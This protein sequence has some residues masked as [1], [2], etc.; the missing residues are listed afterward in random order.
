MNKTSL[1]RISGPIIAII[2]VLLTACYQVYAKFFCNVSPW[3]NFDTV[4]FF[5]CIGFSM[6]CC[7]PIWIEINRSN[8]GNE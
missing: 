8:V 2:I 6:L 5:S 7:I 3:T 4:L 1:A